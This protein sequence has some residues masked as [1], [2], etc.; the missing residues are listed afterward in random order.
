MIR[1][2]GGS[3]RGGGAGVIRGEGW[4]DQGGGGLVIH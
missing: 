1:G 3:D 2:E 4:S